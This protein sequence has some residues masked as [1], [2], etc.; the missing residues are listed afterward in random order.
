MRQT[1]RLVEPHLHLRRLL[2]LAEEVGITI[3]RVPA[4]GDGADH[5]GGA[6]VRLKGR[7]M[8]F[9][10]PTAA[11]AD[12]LAVVASALRGRQEIANRFLPPEIRQLID[13]ETA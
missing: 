11:P 7:E 8:L 3:R 4:A 5:P 13:G 9:L 6:L 12:Q 10:D 1:G 2:D